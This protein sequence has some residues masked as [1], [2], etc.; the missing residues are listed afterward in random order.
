MNQDE[1]TA[2]PHKLLGSWSRTSST[3]EV[4]TDNL[5]ERYYETSH[6]GEGC[7]YEVSVLVG[8]R[9][10]VATAAISLLEYESSL[11]IH[12]CMIAR[13]NAARKKLLEALSVRK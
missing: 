10:L 9:K 13:K 5:C 12:D 2:R 8:D 6:I 7:V 3:V 11:G 4:E 1:A